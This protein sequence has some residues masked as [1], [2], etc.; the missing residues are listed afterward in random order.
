VIAEQVHRPCI[1]DAATHL[2]RLSSRTCSR[3]QNGLRVCAERE[4]S[5][6]NEL[7]I[8]ESAMAHHAI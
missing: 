2:A 8:E 3:L 7:E 6:P 4:A 1:D 5:F